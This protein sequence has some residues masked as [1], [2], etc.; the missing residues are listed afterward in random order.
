MR[1]LAQQHF[2]GAASTALQVVVHS[3]GAPVS[4]P[5]VRAVA[6]EAT[7]LL[8]ADHRVAG[9]VQPQP[10]LTVSRNGRTEVLLAGA[11]A[12]PNDMVRAADALKGRWPRCPGTGSP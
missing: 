3:D 2:G 9:V 7:A 10:G 12:D 11:K 8:S 6:A 1:Q 4:D 5:A